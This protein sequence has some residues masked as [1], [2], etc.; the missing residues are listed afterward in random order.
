MRVVFMGTPE[1]ALVALKQLREHHEIISVYCQP[2]RPAGR[3]QQLRPSA[4]HAFASAHGLP[5]RTPATLKDPEEQAAFTALDADIA[6]VAA[7]GLILPPSILAAPRIGCVNI[8]ASLLPRWRG[9]API[10]RAIMA[11]DTVSGVTIMRME[12]GL[13]TG[14]MLLKRDVAVTDATTAGEL[15]DALA[16]MGSELIVEALEGLGR[17]TLTSQPQPAVGVT[18][19]AKI[20]KAESH[21]DFHRPARDVVRYIH[22]L[23]PVPGAWFSYG[24]ERIRVLTAASAAASGEPGT[25]LDEELLVAC[26]SGAVRLLTL[27][28]SGRSAIAAEA[29]LRGYTLPKGTKLA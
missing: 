20:D 9:A 26:A 24:G 29:F 16:V 7:Y 4:V 25:V 21:I 6:V 17:G 13:D 10:Q 14:P 15:H 23:S 19:A 27:Q 12:R 18:Y 1:F 3:G 22:A 11:G 28:R 2:P 5:V 8:H